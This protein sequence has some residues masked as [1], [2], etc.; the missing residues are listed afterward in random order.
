MHSNRTKNQNSIEITELASFMAKQAKG[1]SD[2]VIG[3]LQN[4]LGQRNLLSE[5]GTL[6]YDNYRKWM[7]STTEPKEEYYF[8]HDATD[9]PPFKKVKNEFDD[10]IKSALKGLKLH[11]L[12]LGGKSG[13][14]GLAKTS[15][16]HEDIIIDVI[17]KTKQ[18]FKTIQKAFYGLNKNSSTGFIEREVFSRS[19]E[20]IGFYVDSK[21][22]DEI[23]NYFDIDKD[24]KIS[25][26]DFK[27]CFGKEVY[28]TEEKYFR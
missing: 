26:D 10:G 6:N 24:G 23:F 1:T 16:I 3:D 19:L 7:S 25:Y 15:S 9:N 18:R 14:L 22:S 8:R 21:I 20:D 27:S 4:I 11:S 5:D 2:D 28:P 13:P 17:D 12:G